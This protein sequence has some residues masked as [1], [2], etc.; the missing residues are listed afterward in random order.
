MEEKEIHNQTAEK[1]PGESSSQHQD[2]LIFDTL[3]RFSD[4]VKTIS[5]DA[6][7]LAQV[8]E[9]NTDF[10]DAT[11]Q[12]L[13]LNIK[14]YGSE[15]PDSL[16]F[17]T[18]DKAY[19]LLN[20]QNQVQ[21]TRDF[22]EVLPRP[23]GKS[24]VLCFLVL[25]KILGNHKMRL[26]DFTRKIREI[27]KIFDYAEYRSL[28]LEFERFSD[29]LEEFHD[30][31]LRLQERSY[32]QVETKY[33]SFD[34]RVLIAESLSLQGRCRRRLNTVKELRQEYEMRATEELNERIIKLNDIV[35]KLTALTVILM[36]PTLIASHFGMNFANMPELRM[37]W[38][39]P[40]VI[41][42]QLVFM[43][44]GYAIFKSKGWL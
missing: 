5:G 29:R 24:T 38:A 41:L 14:E 3:A 9:L 26:E 32:K 2:V 40:A 13:L 42:F 43:G 36:L 4:V 6:L 17:I 19:A 7:D 34:Y 25:N 12:Y 21:I 20:K 10:I 31:L 22:E 11:D 1:L 23:F 15:E 28:A 8:V 30:L 39:Y 16:L 27:E 44:I 35:K 37:W 18:E 33:I